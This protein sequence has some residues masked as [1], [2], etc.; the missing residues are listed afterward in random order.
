M[1]KIIEEVKGLYKIISIEEFRKTPNVEF[2][3]LAGK[4]LPK[5]DS[6]DKVVHKNKAVSPGFND[7]GDR[8]W[9]MHPGQDDNLIVLHGERKVEIY[10]KEHGRVEKFK[11]TSDCVFKNDVQVCFESAVLVWPQGVFHRIT[12]GDEGS[13]SINL[14]THYDDFDI[15]TN[16]NIYT[17]DTQSGEY[18]VYRLGHEDQMA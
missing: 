10:T 9:Y 18:I 13:I 4:N 11:I 1:G 16:F 15:K 3:V 7:E 8:T 6:I 2:T 14:A 5:I 17:L 12:S